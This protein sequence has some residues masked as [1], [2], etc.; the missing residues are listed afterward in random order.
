MGSLCHRYM[1]IVL[2]VKL[3]RCN[4]VAWIYAHLEGVSICHR[5]MCIVLY[6][7]LMRCNGIAWIYAQLEE[8]VGVSLP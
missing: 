3:M 4:G 7:K 8:G 1:C 5:Y 6:V 2:Y